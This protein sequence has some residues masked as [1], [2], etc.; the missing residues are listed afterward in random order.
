LQVASFA[1]EVAT[2]GAIQEEYCSDQR[3]FRAAAT[4]STA[5]SGYDTSD[6]PD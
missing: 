4:F 1:Q 6:F 2:V 3:L 5:S